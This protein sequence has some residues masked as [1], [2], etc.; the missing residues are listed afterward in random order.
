MTDK[1]QEDIVVFKGLY[2]SK[3]GMIFGVCQG[4]AEWKKLP[5]GYIRLFVL[6]AFFM[7]GFFPLGALYLGLAFFLPVK[8]SGSS[9]RNDESYHN[10]FRNDRSGMINDIKNEFENLK[11]RVRHMESDMF[12][13]EKDW[14]SRFHK[15]K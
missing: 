14:D 3:N 15:E 4:L 10:R 5:V 7:T 2:R 9:S 13:K 12:D 11:D 8:E 6:L 1:R